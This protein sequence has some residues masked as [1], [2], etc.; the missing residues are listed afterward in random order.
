MAKVTVK[1][2]EPLRVP[3]GWTWQSRDFVIQLERIIDD[4]YIQL[5]QIEQ[6]L[7]TLESAEEE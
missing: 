3:A 7:K 5:G 2:H 6:R 1:Q 4:I